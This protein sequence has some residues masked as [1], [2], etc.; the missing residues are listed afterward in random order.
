MSSHCCK[1]DPGS[2]HITYHLVKRLSHSQTV[3]ASFEFA[4]LDYNYY[5]YNVTG[6]TRHWKEIKPTLHMVT[7]L[8]VVVAQWQD[9]CFMDVKTASG[10]LSVVGHGFASWPG[11]T[12]DHNKKGTNCILLGRQSLG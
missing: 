3:L 10:W 12:K 6:L 4:K 11:H 5:K 1:S 9:V 8:S 7:T 2:E